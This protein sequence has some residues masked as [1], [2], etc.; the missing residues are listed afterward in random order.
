M[1]A[2]CKDLMTKNPVCCLSSD[3]AE[4]AAQTMKREDIGSVP[5][6]EDNQSKKLVGIVTDRDLALKIVAEGRDP[7]SARVSDVM[8]RELVTCSADDDAQN[9]I[10]AMEDHQ[11][12]RLPVV[13]TTGRIVG[14]IAQADIA[15]RLGDEETGKM[16]GEI[17][18]PKRMGGGGA[19]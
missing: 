7:K 12:R 10:D 17:S 15:Q 11:I 1:A 14:I 4:K 9:A 8:S 5:V 19:R 13:D 2:K 6:V 16:V 18:K 3:S